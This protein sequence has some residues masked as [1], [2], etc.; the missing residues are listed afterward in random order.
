MPTNTAMP[1]LLLILISLFWSTSTIVTKLL[2]PSIDSYTIAF[3]RFAIA[4][5]II[6]PLYVSQKNKP[7]LGFTIKNILPWMIFNLG[8]II[9]FY[10]GIQHTTANSA[11]IIY[12]LIPL[13]TAVLQFLLFRTILHKQ[14]ILGILI[15]FIGVLLVLFM[16]LI[17]GNSAGSLFGNISFLCAALSWTIYTLASQR[18]LKQGVSAITL[19]SISIWVGAI[20][21]GIYS[22]IVI[23][24]SFSQIIH[25]YHLS[26]LIY[27]AIFVT[28]FPFILFQSILKK[29]SAPVAAMTNYLQPIFGFALSW[30]FLQE[31]ITPLFVFGSILTIIGVIITTV[32]ND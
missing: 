4:G 30:L 10:L 31:T 16:P 32:S 26:L 29:T 24:P 18:L 13:I 25:P 20:I 15:G 17:D 9:F 28:V 12:S 23:Q 7:S 3:I 14:K 19:S 8:N 21:T 11:L 6:F 1:L 2:L 22:L 27:L 5:I